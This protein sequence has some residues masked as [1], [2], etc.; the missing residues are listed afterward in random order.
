MRG[1]EGTYIWWPYNQKIFCFQTDGPITWGVIRFYGVQC[2]I[3]TGSFLCRFRIL[4]SVVFLCSNV[5]IN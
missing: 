1:F 5:D 4:L 3:K 2:H